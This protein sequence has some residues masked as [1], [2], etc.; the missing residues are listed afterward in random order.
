MCCGVF[1]R[2][3]RLSSRRRER[4]AVSGHWRGGNELAERCRIADGAGFP[5]EGRAKS[6]LRPYGPLGRL[7]DLPGGLVDAVSL[8]MRWAD[9]EQRRA[10]QCRS[11]R[12]GQHSDF[13]RV[14]QLT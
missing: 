11:E 2:D 9:P 3:D 5:P 10:N 14:L 12:P 1:T 6:P 8:M 4:T 13:H 7:G